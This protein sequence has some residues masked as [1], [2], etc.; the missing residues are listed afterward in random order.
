[1]RTGEEAAIAIVR[2]LLRRRRSSAISIESVRLVVAQ[3]HQIR[4]AAGARPFLDEQF[5]SPGESKSRNDYERE[6]A[7]QLVSEG[8]FVC[9]LPATTTVD[10]KLTPDFV[11]DD[12]LVDAK[13]IEGRLVARRVRRAVGQTGFSGGILILR[14]ADSDYVPLARQVIM[15]AVA[16]GA[17][18]FVR[19]LSADGTVETFGEW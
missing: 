14:V 13:S 16:S 17:L 1:M 15:A 12:M 18:K 10:G 4:R 6:V 8:R 19:L 7:W 2:E 5:L 3:L 11:A 9:A